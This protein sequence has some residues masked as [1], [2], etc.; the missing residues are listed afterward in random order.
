[1]SLVCKYGHSLDIPTFLCHKNHMAVKCYEPH[2]IILFLNFKTLVMLPIDIPFKKYIEIN[3]KFIQNMTKE[4]NDKQIELDNNQKK[5]IDTIKT[6]DATIKEYETTVKEY[7]LLIKENKHTIQK[8]IKTIME[9][10]TT[11]KEYE[12]TIKNYSKTMKDH[13][14]KVIDVLPKQNMDIIGEIVGNIIAKETNKLYEFI[15][16]FFVECDISKIVVENITYINLIK[17]IMNINFKDFNT[18]C[19]E[20]YKKLKEIQI[21]EMECNLQ[22]EYNVSL[23]EIQVKHNS[24]ISEYKKKLEFLCIENCRLADANLNLRLNH[25]SL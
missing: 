15:T 20:N 6:Y 12:I 25:Y 22:I 2:D 9:C 24:E 14:L 5:T 7:E 17:N 13:E 18:T 16:E 11:I 10:E 19:F 1:M 23:A 3:Q 4:Y 21:M 8:H